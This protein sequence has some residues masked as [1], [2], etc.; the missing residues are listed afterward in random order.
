MSGEISKNLRDSPLSNVAYLVFR[1][2]YFV[3]RGLI[4]LEEFAISCFCY[5][6]KIFFDKLSGSG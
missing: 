5:K 3:S 1:I 2:S 6:I 4:R